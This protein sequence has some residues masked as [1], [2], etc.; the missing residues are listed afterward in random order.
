MPTYLPPSILPRSPLLF[1]LLLCIS[2]NTTPTHADHPTTSTRPN[3]LF[4]AVDDLRAEL[5]CYG[6]AVAQ[7]PNID[8]LAKRSLIF[9]RAYCQYPLCNPSRV[10][11]LTG[12]RPDS[13][14]VHDLKKSLRE[15]SATLVTLPQL[16]KQ[17]GYHVQSIGKIYHATSGLLSDPESWSVPPIAGR[18]RTPAP[19]GKPRQPHALPY[20]SP[21]TPDNMLPDGDIA[22]QTIGAL[23]QNVN[24][25]FFLAVGFA[26]PHL[27]FV[28]P[29]KYWRPFRETSVS[30][31]A[32]QN[33][34]LQA[35]DFATNNSGELRQYTGILKT[36]P[37]SQEEQLHL[38][39]GYL[40]CIAYMDAQLDKVLAELD[41][42]N[43]RQNTIIVFW[44]DHGYLLGEHGT[45]GKHT[46]WEESCRVPLMIASPSSKNAGQ[47]SK[48]L[49][50]LVDVYPTLAELCGL[51]PPH[52]LEG[53]SLTSILQNPKSKI[54]EGALTSWR[55]RVPE[56]GMVEGRSLRTERYRLIEWRSLKDK[57]SPITYELYDYQED[58]KE[59]QNLASRPS[60][61]TRLKDLKTQLKIQWKSGHN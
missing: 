9:T 5:G 6:S 7:S 48:A 57:N 26:K 51:T 29:E 55:K 31:P 53:K 19:D 40:A 59:T 37:I 36:G 27:P 42:L 38:K 45:W 3:V 20:E 30:L 28:A 15:T 50:E 34:P 32:N 25:P 52:R 56:T 21:D 58:P 23:K 39:Q 8:A 24:R 41:R 18:N 11:I 13:A 60:H 10:S 22:E 44:G 61:Q 2:L 49:V 33:P 4:I 35:P 14:G 47:Q 46:L 12:L 43:L 1:F 16:F 17:N 54:K